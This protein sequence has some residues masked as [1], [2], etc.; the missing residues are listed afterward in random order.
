MVE[1]LSYSTA[2]LDTAGVATLEK[3]GITKAQV[4]EIGKWATK[5]VDKDVV[6]ALA[7]S[8]E[9]VKILNK[10]RQAERG[11][12]PMAEGETADVTTKE[13][14][15]LELAEVMDDA[16]YMA[17]TDKGKALQKKADRLMARLAKY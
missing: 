16:D 1:Q 13:A 9:G 4:D 5:N 6:G 14:I 11:L 7:K 3:E 15:E 8:A 12:T 10:L 17:N 2:Q